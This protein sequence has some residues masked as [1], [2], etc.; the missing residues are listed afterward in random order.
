MPSPDSQSAFFSLR[1]VQPEDEAFLFR[2]FGE[3]QDQLALIRSNQ[4]LWK[5]LVDVQYRGR[6]MTYSEIYP[7]AEDAIICR[8]GEAAG[9]LLINREPDCLRI[10][11]I[12]ILAGLRGQGIGSWALRQCQQQAAEA[13]VRIDLSVNPMNP[14]RLLYERLGFQVTGEGAMHVTMAWSAA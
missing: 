3:T 8:A 5:T 9:R 4:A 2:L 13:G 6:K 1:P 7:A 10:V 11:D 14:A 12:A